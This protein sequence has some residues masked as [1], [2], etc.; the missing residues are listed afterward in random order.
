MDSSQS[1]ESVHI[2][3]L[4]AGPVLLARRPGADWRD[5]QDEW[6][7]Y[8]TSLGPYAE[9]DVIGFFEQQYHRDEERWPLTR[10][11]VAG[12]FANE[13]ARELWSDWHL[14]DG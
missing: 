1:P 4:R 14:A 3:F 12:F 5:L 2:V 13:D 7:D 6:D 9:E 11:Q 10:A 8:M